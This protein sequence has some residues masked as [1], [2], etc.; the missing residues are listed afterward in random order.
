MPLKVTWLGGVLCWIGVALGILSLTGVF[1]LIAWTIGPEWW[2]VGLAFVP[3]VYSVFLYKGVKSHSIYFNDLPERIE[4][5]SILSNE[6][7]C[8]ST[9]ACAMSMRPLR[10]SL[11]QYLFWHHRIQPPFKVWAGYCLFICNPSMTRAYKAGRAKPAHAADAK[12]GVFMLETTCFLWFKGAVEEGGRLIGRFSSEHLGPVRTLKDRKGFHDIRKIEVW[13]DLGTRVAVRAAFDD[14]KI[15]ISRA[16]TQIV[17]LMSTQGH[18]WLHAVSTWAFMPKHDNKFVRFMGCASLF[19]N[20][21]G[22]DG[23]LPAIA[24]MT[25]R[26]DIITGGNPRSELFKDVL[27]YKDEEYLCGPF[28][29]PVPPFFGTPLSVAILPFSRFAAFAQLLFPEFM[30]LLD[31]EPDPI[32]ASPLALFFAT[33][34]HCTDHWS[35]AKMFNYAKE[36]YATALAAVDDA[37]LGG[38][39]PGEPQLDYTTLGLGAAITL[40]LTED[41]PKVFPVYFRDPPAHA[42][43]FYRRVYEFARQLDPELAYH[44][45][46][47]IIK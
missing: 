1:V 31:E 5:D 43:K 7:P 21:L 26:A 40:G 38:F 32:T 2:F 20:H 23:G 14:V 17:W 19:F 30:R 12:L 35:F 28:Q 8:A 41:W 24:R 37:K 33:V 36:D 29:A 45:Q 34:L 39:N 16:F 25:K 27:P 13:V 15:K 6:L 3:L 44:L 10:M 22:F 4:S 46:A 47:C 11:G 9:D 42:P 18:A